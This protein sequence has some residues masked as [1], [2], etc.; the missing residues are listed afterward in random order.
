M[1]VLKLSEL[2]LRISESSISN[3]RVLKTSDLVLRTSEFSFSESDW[4]PI[5]F[6]SLACTVFLQAGK[7]LDTGA[8]F[9][10]RANARAPWTLGPRHS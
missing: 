10:D 6:S 2:V 7:R 9:R 4:L 8:D 1:R 3:L 5:Q